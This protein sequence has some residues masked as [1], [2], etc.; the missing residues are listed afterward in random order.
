[1]NNNLVFIFKT[2]IFL[3][4]LCFNCVYCNELLV[5]KCFYDYM[6]NDNDKVKFL[7]ETFDIRPKNNYLDF[8]ECELFQRL[9]DITQNLPLTKEIWY[10]IINL[11]N[12]NIK[13]GLDLQAFNSTYYN[14][15]HI[16]GTDLDRD[17]KI[18]K[19]FG[20]LLRII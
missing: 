14:Y 19:K 11:V 5:N 16:L 4:V 9:T 12:G 1:M 15:K 8:Y 3:I 2:F 6:I 18:I 10:Y 13:Y 7:F 17:W 20:N